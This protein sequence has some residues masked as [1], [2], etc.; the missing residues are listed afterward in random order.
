[1]AYDSNPIQ[2]DSS[3]DIC[4]NFEKLLEINKNVDFNS[5]INLRIE[6]YRKAFKDTDLETKWTFVGCIMIG[7]YKEYYIS[8]KNL[9]LA[10]QYVEDIIY[11]FETDNRMKWFTDK[12]R[13]YKF[14]E[15][16][17]FLK[18]FE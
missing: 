18:T 4:G 1:M 8:P 17:T 10:I 6:A 5:Y 16:L 12:V 7:L 2:N 14:Y 9:I 13:L 11:D 3:A 15:T